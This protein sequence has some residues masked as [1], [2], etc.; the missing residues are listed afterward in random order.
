MKN[1]IL[2]PILLFWTAQ[3]GGAEMV[4][5]RD[6]SPSPD[7][8][9]VAFAWQGDIWT[10]SSDGGRATRLT[11]HPAYDHSPAWSPDGSLLAFASD[12]WGNDDIFIMD[13]EGGAPTR[14]TFF[15]GTDSLSGFSPD[16]KS[17][18][19]SSRRSR[20][21][22]RMS[23]I[24]S[25]SVESPT[26]PE[27]LSPLL[28]YQPTLSPDGNTLLFVRGTNSR[29][30]RGYLG[31]AN[32][33]IWSTDLASGDATPLT[34]FEGNDHLPMWE[35]DGERVWFVSERGG[36][37]H[38]LWSS[39]P[40]GNRARKKTSFTDLSIRDA[41]ISW[42]GSLIAMEVGGGITLFD[43][44]TEE[45][46]T[47]PLEALGDSLQNDA[48]WV[49]FG[50]SA[51]SFD[52]LDKKTMAVAVDGEIWVVDLDLKESHRVTTTREMES[53]VSWAGDGRTLLFV[54]DRTGTEQIWA[55][56]P[57]DS[58]TDPRHVLSWE[59]YPLTNGPMPHHHPVLS[60]NGESLSYVEDYG[61]LLIAPLTLPSPQKEKSPSSDQPQGDEEGVNLEDDEDEEVEG[62]GSIR[63]G[64]EDEEEG[65]EGSIPTGKE[66]EES[67]GWDAP[68]LGEPTT[69]RTGWDWPW[70][71][72]SPDSSW[73]AWH[74]EDIEHNSDVWIAPADGSES[75]LNLSAHPDYDTYPAWSENGR[76]LAF[77]TRRYGD[78]ADIWYLFLRESDEDLTKRER[79]D[80]WKEEAEAQKKEKPETW[81]QIDTDRLPL[82][83][84]SL[85][86]LDGNETE[87]V[88]THD[89]SRV[90]FRGSHDGSDL[91][92]IS[93]S[94]GSPLKI[95]S[96]KNPRSLRLNEK[97]DRVEYLTLQGQVGSTK[98]TSKN[99][100][101][102]PFSIQYLL[103][104]VARRTEVFLEAWRTMDR[105][106]YDENHH[107]AD[108]DAIRDRYLPWAISAAHA[109]D[110]DAVI[111]IMLGELNG[112]HLGYYGRVP[113]V[114]ESR[115][116][117]G[118]LGLDWTLGEEGLDITGVV[119]EG[120]SDFEDGPQLGETVLSIN[121]SPVLG[122][123]LHRL[124]TNLSG[125]PVRLQLWGPT[126]E[127]DGEVQEIPE[128]GVIFLNDLEGGAFHSPISVEM[129]V[130]GKEV[131]PAGEGEEGT[132]HHHL[133]IDGAFVPEGETVL[134]DDSH[135][136][137]GDGSSDTTLELEPGEHTLTLQFADSTHISYGEAWSTTVTLEV[138]PLEDERELIVRPSSSGTI[139]GLRYEAWVEGNREQV[140]VLSEGRLGYVHI[141]GMNQSSLDRFEAELYLIGHGKE[142]LVI[143]VRDNGGG[144]TT[145]YLLAMLMVQRHA[146]TIP[147]GAPEGSFGYPQSRLPMYAWPHPI[148][149]LANENSY[150]NAE[151]FSHAVQT[152]ERGKVVG[153]PTHGAVISTGS[154]RLI[155]GSSM[156]FPFRGWY[157]A[158][159]DKL[160]ANL[161]NGA[162][163]PDILVLLH[164]EDEAAG[165]DPQLERAIKVLLRDLH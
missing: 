34:H 121:G 110:F 37:S 43:T 10:V 116:S 141:R 135:I 17:I 144:W 8:S 26:T 112:S 165:K 2:I 160:G 42:D 64:E 151:I 58:E 77:S 16:G 49:S 28:G 88:M 95:T 7:G 44:Q 124:L 86:R 152:L 80:L 94:G 14:L 29:Y 15:S 134:S 63:A 105:G 25:V 111:D 127:V 79:D 142:G 36:D 106:F 68:S 40:E 90:V 9:L 161:E 30:R 115:E 48:E 126:T 92:S 56:R 156:R 102:H 97:G 13:S 24:Y 1:R 157:V 117:T 61:T 3:L 78:S 128:E 18:L 155:D 114:D 147:R 145:D 108:W 39:T 149:V 54:S 132:G 163:I 119:M 130:V 60:P 66:D 22:F 131:M 46:S 70:V 6:P 125:D 67:A 101:T 65:G 122:N 53:S 140:D 82:R 98:T 47:L 72:W 123:N 27:P 19:F 62:E 150:S 153:V 103:N 11:I 113:A 109:R 31:S 158:D 20:T 154:R 83:I 146:Y 164:P 73:L 89:G 87:M 59:A 23:E 41:N 133:I 69:I 162:A 74:V 96:G 159:G 12:R 137:F 91:Y 81:V 104:R 118:M 143:D 21:V 100:Q 45:L 76:V 52:I 120:P 32:R 129:G 139:T 99:E 33:E 5:P 57:S 55:A 136:H 138:L 4:F 85:T 50:D 71:S 84:R 38:N 75:P 148:I 51:Q 93:L 35:P 107:G